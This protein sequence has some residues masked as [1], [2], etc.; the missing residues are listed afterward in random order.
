MRRTALF[1]TAVA[2]SC[3]LA[4]TRAI[5]DP[6]TITSGSIVLPGP[7]LLQT[8]PI[9][10]AG[11]RGFSIEGV[12]LTGE[13][14]FDPLAQC[15]PCEP[16]PDFSVGA[17]LGTFAI[18]G[19]AT[20]DGATYPRINRLD[21]DNFA[22]LR[23]EGTATLPPV[24]GSSLVIRAPFTL[25]PRSLFNYQRGAAHEPPE[26][27]TVD[28]RGRG[29]ATVAFQ[30]EVIN[31]VPLWQFSQMR[32]DFAA[33]PEPSTLVLAGAGCAAALSRARRRRKGRERSLSG[34]A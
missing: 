17:Q 19:D 20:L 16:T 1:L 33:T 26:L 9:S 30:A 12:V 29:T 10:I 5:A 24:A 27:A 28:L 18:F 14:R 32:Y 6:V 8:G 25:A 13:G 22:F 4:D 34:T 21:S 2:L 15:F 7:S 3:V 31:D 23:L 11:T